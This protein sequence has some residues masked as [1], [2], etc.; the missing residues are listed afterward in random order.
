M[1]NRRVAA[2]ERRIAVLGGTAAKKPRLIF[3]FGDGTDPSS[4]KDEAPDEKNRPIVFI[5]PR[6]RLPEGE[7]K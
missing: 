2:I 1:F 7:K 3:R 4:E 5:M 6:P